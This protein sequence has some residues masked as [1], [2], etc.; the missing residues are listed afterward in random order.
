MF[1]IF[2]AASLLL[3][4]FVVLEQLCRK[5]LRLQE[6]CRLGFAQAFYSA[7][8]ASVLLLLVS[9]LAQPVHA[10]RLTAHP[11]VSLFLWSANVA[12]TLSADR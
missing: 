12:R 2:M 4:C 1:C 8:H 6:T 9:I 11:S 3:C 7:W 5:R 10:V